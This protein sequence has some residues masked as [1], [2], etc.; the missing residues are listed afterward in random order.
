MQ[1]DELIWSV[2]N[3]QFCSYKVKTPTQNFCRNEYNLTGLCTRQSCPLANSRYATVREKEGVLYLYMKT[4]ERAHTPANMWE[5]VKLSNNYAKALEQIDKELIYWPNFITH[6]CKQ[7]ITK[8]TQYLIKMRRLSLSQQPKLVGIKKKLDRREATRERKALAAAHLEKSIEKEL[9]ERLR[10]KAYGDAPLNVNEDVWRQV[11]DLDKGKERDLDLED[12]DSQYDE[13]EEEWE[14][15]EREFVEDDSEEESVGDLED[16]SGS[17]FEEF[18]S[19]EGESGQEFPSDLEVSDDEAGDE[20]GSEGSD[21]EAEEKGGKGAKSAA[22][23]NGKT[24]GPAAGTKRKA[25]ARDPKKGGKRRP[26]VEVEYEMETE[27]LSREML[28]NW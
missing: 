18:D 21:G 2:I 24:K 14:G 12:E 5:R 10:S 27:P 17:E 9:L 25:P 22:G 20:D 23:A 11:L 4:I 8:I 28:R 16:Y 15:G 6:K 3:H 13:E 7:R 26:K 1:S 19:D